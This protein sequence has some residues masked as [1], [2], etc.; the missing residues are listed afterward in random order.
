[1]LYDFVFWL[2]LQLNF[3]LLIN[4]FSMQYLQF[5]HIPS[6]T[7]LDRT[8]WISKVKTNHWARLNRKRKI[9]IWRPGIFLWGCWWFVW[10]SRLSLSFKL[11]IKQSCKN[12]CTISKTPLITCNSLG[13]PSIFALKHP[14]MM[15]KMTYI[16]LKNEVNLSKNMSKS[17]A[18][19][20]ESSSDLTCK[21]LSSAN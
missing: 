7:L 21:M 14:V 3:V 5:Q 13:K 4:A 2:Q 1:M 6:S 12:S 18:L 16:K 19:L 8:F 17:G 11:E 15:V 10:W 9:V 20:F